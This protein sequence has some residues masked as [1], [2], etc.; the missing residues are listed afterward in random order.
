MALINYGQTVR[1]T[2]QTGMNDTS[3]RSHAILTINLRDQNN[4]KV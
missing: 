3:S 1:K 4:G 2:G